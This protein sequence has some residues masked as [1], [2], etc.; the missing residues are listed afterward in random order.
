MFVLIPLCLT[1]LSD[2][3]I[4]FEISEFG[5]HFR[6]LRLYSRTNRFYKQAG[7]TFTT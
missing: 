7:N 4:Q 6:C 5:G 2:L 3:K 1:K